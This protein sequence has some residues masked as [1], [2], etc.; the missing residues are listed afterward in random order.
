MDLTRFYGTDMRSKIKRLFDVFVP[1]FV[2]QT[3]IYGMTFFDTM[4]SGHAGAPQLAGTAIGANLWM[5]IFATVNGIL[6][7]AT[8][9]IAHLIG[10]KQR[11]DVGKVIRHGLM[12]S[13]VFS[14][15][16]IV[17]AVLLLPL[18]LDILKLEPVVEHVAVYYLAGIGM[19]IVPFFMGTVLRALLDTLGGTSLTMK[20]YLLALPINGFLNYILI[21][22]KLGL[23]ALGGIGAGMATGITCWL[24]FGMFVFVVK[25][26]PSY[27]DIKILEGHLNFNKA[28]VKEYL[29][30]GVPIGLTIFMESGIFAVVV[31]LQAKFGTTV[32]AAS[33]AAMCFS[34]LLYMLPLSVA[35]SM[36]IIIGVEAG[37][38]RWKNA[39]QYGNLSL[40]FNG[41]CALFLPAICYVLRYP[42]A[43]MYVTEPEVI[44]YTVLFVI[45]SCFFIMM[46]AIASPV[47]G[48]LRGY[49][50][51]RAPFV[52]SFIAY[53]LVC[54]PAGLV[55]D[56]VFHRGPAAYWEGL[57]LGMFAF[58][59]ILLLRLIQI[60]KRIKRKYKRIT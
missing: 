18:L 28:L 40:T 33:Q 49:K 56:L 58:A 4:M 23:P 31:L 35:M 32:I 6:L 5:P 43:W 3:A 22:G 19:G 60:R 10:G 1:I 42:I 36:T 46:D 45:Y 2:T 47:Q 11:Q 12:L 50:D 34:N 54:T 13:I 51:V 37:A 55:L 44:D 26:H 25:K 20:I 39:R 30:I 14:L 41:F 38:R 52:A 17:A 8:P 29:H 24:V 59:F 15:L 9:I 7:A 27:Q 16:L 21:F 48:I 53:W 57:D